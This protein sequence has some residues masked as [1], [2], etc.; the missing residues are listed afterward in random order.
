MHQKCAAQVPALVTSAASASALA[1][2][3]SSDPFNLGI[4]IEAASPGWGI[5]MPIAVLS[6]LE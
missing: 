1:S 4:S 5:R 2:P 6:E 3:V